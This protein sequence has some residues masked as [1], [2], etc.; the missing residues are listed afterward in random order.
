MHF[1]AVYGGWNYWIWTKVGM[2]EDIGVAD[3]MA[4]LV[5]G[6]RRIAMKISIKEGMGTPWER[7]ALPSKFA[8]KCCSFT[9]GLCCGALLVCYSW[10]TF[11]QP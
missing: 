6:S 2:K 11:F 9:L 3:E 1:F 8:S 5:L 4:L 7:T 10:F